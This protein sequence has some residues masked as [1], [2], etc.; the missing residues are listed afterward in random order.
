MDLSFPVWSSF[1]LCLCPP[2][3]PSVSPYPFSLPTMPKVNHQEGCVRVLFYIY[4]FLSPPSSH[5]QLVEPRE[6]TK[7][8]CWGPVS[9]KGGGPKQDF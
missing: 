6:S 4:F 9:K 3:L 2:S 7:A 1:F 5:V 8:T